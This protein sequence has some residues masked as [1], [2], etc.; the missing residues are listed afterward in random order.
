L[1]V[2]IEETIGS[3]LG[4]FGDCVFVEGGGG[5]V[6]AGE[7]DD[8]EEEEEEDDEV[9]EEGGSVQDGVGGRGGDY[10][11]EG[12]KKKGNEREKGKRPTHIHTNDTNPDSRNVKHKGERKQSRNV[13]N[14]DGR[15]WFSA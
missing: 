11:N 12:T 5:E 4:E 10:G 3:A 6:S 8:E 14:E 2:L 9:D 15:V 13:G 1:G 7:G